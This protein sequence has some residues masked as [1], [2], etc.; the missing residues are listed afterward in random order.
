M[1]IEASREMVGAEEQDCG[2][3]GGCGNWRMETNYKWR[4]D[5]K[6]MMNNFT[7]ELVLITANH[8]R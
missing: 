1:A 7:R 2:G 6:F 8:E 3:G 5:G 4:E